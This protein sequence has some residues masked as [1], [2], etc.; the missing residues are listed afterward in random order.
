MGPDGDAEPHER[1]VDQALGGEQQAEREGAE[2]LV[3]PVGHD[4]RQHDEPDLLRRARLRHVV[5]KRMADGEVDGRHQ[6]RG[7]DA[8]H[9]G[10]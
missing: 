3:H 6:H 2:D 8:E 7:D 9:E 4:Q 1:L 5:S 10:L